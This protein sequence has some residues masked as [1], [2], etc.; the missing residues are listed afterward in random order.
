MRR[1]NYYDETERRK[2]RA[3]T[4][5]EAREGTGKK[6]RTQGRRVTLAQQVEMGR[7]AMWRTVGDRYDM[8]DGVRYRAKRA[9]DDEGDDARRIQRL[10][11]GRT[12]YDD[13]G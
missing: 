9:R 8:D 2:R 3:P 12:E 7:Q 10:R 6:R 5:G 11:S 1:D 13:G 4:A